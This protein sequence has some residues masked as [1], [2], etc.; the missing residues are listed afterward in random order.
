MKLLFQVDAAALDGQE[1][2]SVDREAPNMANENGM[3]IDSTDRLDCLGLHLH[4][5]NH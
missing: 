5:T 2:V 4:P 3:T 1:L